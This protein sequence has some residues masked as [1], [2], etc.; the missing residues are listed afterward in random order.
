MTHGLPREY[1]SMFVRLFSFA[2]FN[3]GC[4][5]EVDMLLSFFVSFR[6]NII[7]VLVDIIRNS[8]KEKVT[9]IVLATLRV[10]IHAYF[11][12]LVF[13]LSLFN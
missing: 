10:R 5:D 3:I 12:L 4:H 7:P 13:R 6:S 11:A 9:R 8:Q 2:F 1:A